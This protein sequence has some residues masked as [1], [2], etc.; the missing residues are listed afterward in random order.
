MRP[1]PMGSTKCVCCRF[2]KEDK[3]EQ[4]AQHLV[5][6]VDDIQD[7]IGVG[8]ITLDEG[9]IL[10]GDLINIIKDIRKLQEHKP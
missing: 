9:I 1:L 4:L 6:G 3:T 8:E 7:L 5:R 2:E 10:M